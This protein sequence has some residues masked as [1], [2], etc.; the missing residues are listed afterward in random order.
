MDAVEHA[1]ARARARRAALRRRDDAGRI[2]QAH[3]K[4]RRRSSGAS[5]RSYVGEP[6]VED[7]IAILR[8]LKERYEVHHGVRIKDA[9]LVAAAMLSHRY[10][11]RPL[12]ARQ[13]DR[14]CRRSRVAAAHGDRL[15]C[16]RRSTSRAPDH[17][18]RDRAQGAQAR[19]R[20]RRQRERLAKLEQELAESEGELDRLEG[21][22]AEREGRHQRLRE[23]KEADR[24]GQVEEQASRSATAIS[25]KARELQ[26]RHACRS[27]ERELDDGQA[28]ARR[29]CRQASSML[30][31]EV[32]DEDIA[33]VVA[34]VDRHP[35]LDDARRRNRRSYSRWKSGCTQR[36]VGQ[37]EARSRGGQRRAPRPRRPAGPATGRS[38]RSSSSAPPA[39]ARPNWRARWP[40]SSSTTSRR[41]SASTC[42]STWRSTRCRG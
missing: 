13:G 26:L 29:G 6:T 28:E 38:A 33:E 3:R 42:R 35:G 8:G 21:A 4:G 16:R 14:S 12:P 10:I 24:G 20:T 37:D 34:Q 17:A 19:R 23:L 39:S 31:E 36:V 32:D 5:S 22:V 1:Q 18:A 2:P 25:N 40:S 11:T 30:K 27:C 15:A 7:T 41:W 9:A